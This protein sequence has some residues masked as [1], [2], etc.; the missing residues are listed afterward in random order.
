MDAVPYVCVVTFEDLIFHGWELIKD[1]C[2]FRDL[3]VSFLLTEEKFEDEIAMD[4]KV[5]MKCAKFTP[6]KNYHMCGIQMTHNL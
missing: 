5:A 3:F 6:L 1:F 2:N 4:S